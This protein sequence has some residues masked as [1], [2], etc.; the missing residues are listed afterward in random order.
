[1]ENIS[2]RAGH[3]RVRPGYGWLSHSYRSPRRSV[4]PNPL[5]ISKYRIVNDM[6][7]LGVLLAYFTYG[8]SLLLVALVDW[9]IYKRVKDV[10]CCYS[11]EAQ[12]RDSPMVAKLAPFNLELHDYYR[13]LKSREQTP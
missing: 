4:L 1:M 12:F 8:I 9:L 11:C 7:V 2:P 10:G 3:R 6:V 5:E 13:N